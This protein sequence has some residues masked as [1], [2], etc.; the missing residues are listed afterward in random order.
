MK[1][2]R[3]KILGTLLLISSSIFLS[4]PESS[5]VLG[6]KDATGNP[7][8]VG[9][10]P[11]ERAS[12]AQCS[13]ALVAPRIV[14]TAAHCLFAD[15]ARYWVS[16][17]GVTLADQSSPRIQVERFLI[18]SDFS[19][20]SFP[21]QNDFGIIILKSGFDGYK[22][23]EYASIEDIRKWAE[24]KE[25]VTHIGYGC[26]A[27]V[28]KPPCGLTSQTP[29]QFDTTLETD[30]PRQFFS[31]KPGTFSMTRISVEKTICGGDSG[32]PL[33][34]FQNGSW[35]YIGAQSSSN[36][37]GCTPTCDT[38][39]VATQGLPAANSSLVKEAFALV[40]TASKISGPVV[41]KVTITCVKGKSSKKV[42]GNKPSCP[43]G[44]KKK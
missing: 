36:G 38:N 22:N 21:Y 20:S 15:P 32:S 40:K 25:P 41:K 17:P 4:I 18:P 12:Q 34:K 42:T 10:L 26:T 11:N 33:L 37:A 30:V 28:D 24:S 29:N 43:A 14:F 2:R 19:S 5:A 23:I 13:G 35:I 39:C 6:G 31:I 44:Y 1:I 9:I 27:L 8:V 16:Q 7:I 3:T